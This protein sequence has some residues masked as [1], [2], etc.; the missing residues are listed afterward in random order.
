MAMK[1]G[2]YANIN[3]KRK[4]IK[5]GSGERMAAPGSKN[6]PTAADFKASAKT[7]KKPMAK[8]K[9]P[10]PKGMPMGMPKMADAMMMRK[11]KK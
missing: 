5:A 6:A 2:L 7:A 4:R 9:A 3:A 1:P 10:M 11:G 8:G